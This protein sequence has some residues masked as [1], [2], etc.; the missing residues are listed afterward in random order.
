MSVESGDKTW[1][2]TF[3]EPKGHQGG[4]YG[5]IEVFGDK[6][7]V[8]TKYSVNI[9]DTKTGAAIDSHTLPH[10]ARGAAYVNIETFENYMAIIVNGWHYSR[11]D[12]YYVYSSH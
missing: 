12:R 11:N 5:K 4:F 8:A 2:V 1:E 9:L 10:A 6:V 3:L 7:V